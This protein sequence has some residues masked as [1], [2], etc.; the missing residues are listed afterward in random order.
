MKIIEKT[1]EF[2]LT[3][4]TAVAAITAATMPCPNR[5]IFICFIPPEICRFGRKGIRWTEMCMIFHLFFDAFGL[6]CP[7]NADYTRFQDAAKHTTKIQF[8]FTRK[9]LVCQSVFSLNNG[10]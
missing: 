1:T 9:L 7:Q 4:D 5:L 3:E 8:Y 2:E 10:E 6:K